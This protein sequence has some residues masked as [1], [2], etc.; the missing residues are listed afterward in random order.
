MPSFDFL[1]L[2][3]ATTALVSLTRPAVCRD[4]KSP[5]P[6]PST[7]HKG[8]ELFGQTEH[9]PRELLVGRDY[10]AAHAATSGYRAANEAGPTAAVCVNGRAAGYPCSK[11]DLLSVTT[12]KQL[13]GAQGT[14][15]IINDVWGWT[16]E[17]SGRECVA[18]GVQHHNQR[19]HPFL[20]PMSQHPP[21]TT[22]GSRWWRCR[23][24]RRSSR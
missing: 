11:V 16:H 4:P 3:L 5:P 22:K 9:N 14:C 20:S 7:P 2:A 15:G 24:A 8:C 18:R 17:G 1:S 13:C 23:P 6:A 19:L 12:N 21:S 10:E